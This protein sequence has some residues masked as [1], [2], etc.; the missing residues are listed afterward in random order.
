[1][2][3]KIKDAAVKTGEY[4]SGGQTKARWQN[5]GALMEDDKGGLFCMLDRSFNPAGVPYKEGSQSIII[6]FFDPKPRDQSDHE[7]AK[8]NGFQPQ[9]ED[10]TDIPF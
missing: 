4:Q 7:K 3:K 10:L 6:S 2:A 5:V 9:K 8:A 1:M